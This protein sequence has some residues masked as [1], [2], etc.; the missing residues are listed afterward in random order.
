MI[1]SL[2]QRV[3]RFSSLQNVSIDCSCPLKTH[4]AAF[5]DESPRCS[6]ILHILA[7]YN[8]GNLILINN[9]VITEPFYPSR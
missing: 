9:V 8:L 7:E 3:S 1:D 2:L 5:K 4:G 6:L